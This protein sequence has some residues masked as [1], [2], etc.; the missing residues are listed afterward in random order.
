MFLE[1]VILDEMLDATTE[2]VEHLASQFLTKRVC[3]PLAINSLTFDRDG[4]KQIW[5][6]NPK[7]RSDGQSEKLINGFIEVSP[8]S[9]NRKR[10][11]VHVRIVSCRPE[12][13]SLWFDLSQ[14]IKASILVP[15]FPVDIIVT[16]LNK[17]VIS[18]ELPVSPLNLTVDD[19]AIERPQ[20]RAIKSIYLPKKP[21]FLMRWKKA[22][23]IIKKHRAQHMTEFNDGYAERETPTL[24][25]LCDVLVDVFSRKP[26]TRTVENIVAAGDN[27][28][29]K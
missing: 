4:D 27:G 18:G 2:E 15:N 21:K 26:S 24:D 28:L 17:F 25:E 14:Y 22:Y 5:I 1:Q 19:P 16:P 20:V 7:D 3:I 9:L 23:V 12:L 10:K 6:F 13:T 8:V 11:P 29:L